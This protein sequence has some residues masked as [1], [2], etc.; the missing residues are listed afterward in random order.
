MRTDQVLMHASPKK[1]LNNILMHRLLQLTLSMDTHDTSKE[2]W[3]KKQIDKLRVW[4]I[5]KHI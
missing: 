5:I 4:F 3:A 2:Q 1:E